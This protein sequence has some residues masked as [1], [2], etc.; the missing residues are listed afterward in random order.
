MVF[1][2]TPTRPAAIQRLASVREPRPALEM[3]RSRV[4]KGRLALRLGAGAR[5]SRS[6]SIMIRESQQ[7][8]TTEKILVRGVRQL[9]TLRGP[10]GPR[11]GAA[12][13]DLGMIR[14]G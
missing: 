2:L 8:P 5:I 10:A 6:Y 9:I 13:H 7:S 14:D 12:L 4:F 11:R 1:P 3:T